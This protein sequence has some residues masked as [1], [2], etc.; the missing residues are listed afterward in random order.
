MPDDLSQSKI[1]SAVDALNEGKADFAGIPPIASLARALVND[2]GRIVLDASGCDTTAALFTDVLPADR[3]TIE[4]TGTLPVPNQ[5]VYTVSPN[6]DLLVGASGQQLAAVRNGKWVAG[7][8][9]FGFNNFVM[10]NLL[11]LTFPD[12]VGV[13][14]QIAVNSP[15]SIS[16]NNLQK[17]QSVSFPALASVAGHFT[18][19]SSLP[20]LTSAPFPALATVNG[21]FSPF[22]NG[23]PLLTS[24]S[25]PALTAVG[26]MFSLFSSSQPKVTSASFPALTTVGGAFMVA[27]YTNNPSLTSFSFPALATVNGYFNPN[28]TAQMNALTSFSFPALTTVGAYFTA[29]GGQSVLLT[30]LSFPAL[31]TVGGA[32]YCNTSEIWSL[33]SASFPSLATVGG[34]FSIN[35]GSNSPSFRTF[36][37]SSSLKTVLGDISTSLHPLDGHNA[38]V[39]STRYPAFSTQTAPASAFSTTPVGTTCTVTLAG[40]GFVTGDWV[41]I[42]GLG[43]GSAAGVNSFLSKARIPVTVVDANTFTYAVSA[44]SIIPFGTATINREEVTVYP[45]TRNGHKY[46]AT[47]TGTTG[48]TE[49]TWPTVVGNTVVDGGVTWRC[50]ES[51]F[52]NLMPIFAAMDGTNGTTLYGAN[53]YISL[54]AADATN[55]PTVTAIS[56][57][58]GV[59]SA[60]TSAAHGL[61]VGTHF[62]LRGATGTATP[63]N[64][65]WQVATA[66]TPTTFTFAVPAALVAAAAGTIRASNAC[67]AF[68]GTV[69]IPTAIVHSVADAHLIF[70]SVS[71][72]NAMGG[73]PLPV[74]F[75][76]RY[77]RNGST[78]GFS[79]FDGAYNGMSIWFDATT[80]RWAVTPVASVGVSADVLKYPNTQQGVLFGGV[81]TGTTTST[82]TVASAHGGPTSGTTRFTVAITGCTGANVSLNGTH[83]ATPTSATAFTINVTNPAAGTPDGKVTVLNQAYNQGQL[84][85]S[86][87]AAPVQAVTATVTLNSHGYST[88]DFIHS[89]SAQGTDAV[90]ANDL[91]TSAST[92]SMPSAVTVVDANTFTFTRFAS[93][94][95]ALGAAGVFTPYTLILATSFPYVRRTTSTDVAFFNILKLRARGVVTAVYGV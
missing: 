93:V 83:V 94:Q 47:T 3:L 6:Y 82:I 35:S 68:N 31:T 63:Y 32:F 53:R 18:F 79:R 33:T 19:L 22:Q 88:G 51:S 9:I 40:H 62:A 75:T 23:Y 37:L 10:D 78:N 76:D 95:P 64:S 17:L 16:L 69:K 24:I 41:T 42:Q 74:F 55:D 25:F 27:Q 61:T 21:N 52:S 7:F 36:S 81:P 66:P 44:T 28:T 59:A 2:Q 58:A 71:L 70:G 29:S 72:S 12:L 73:S 92:F 86:S 50:V 45:I 91:F 77:I 89:H 67:P 34:A 60:T 85:S 49:P 54:L 38:W 20:S 26:G 30:T 57:T 87:V 46:V 14:G 1:N 11:T 5:V 39:A 13:T 48:G 84:S 65:V 56:S 90:S 80:T 43:A 8:N 4:Y 15:S